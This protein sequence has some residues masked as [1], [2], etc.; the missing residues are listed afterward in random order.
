MRVV[1]RVILLAPPP[2]SQAPRHIQLSSPTPGS[3]PGHGREQDAPV[4]ARGLG[5][6]GGPRT[7]SFPS[8]SRS[9]GVPMGKH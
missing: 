1:P 9:L 4:V 8:T 3:P 7:H 2:V 6:P 5:L